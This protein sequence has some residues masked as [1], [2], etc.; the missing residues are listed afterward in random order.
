MTEEGALK[1]K[2]CEWLKER[3]A[4]VFV[5]DSVGIYDP[6]HRCFRKNHDPFR[7]KGVSDVLGVWKARFMAIECKIKGKYATTEQKHFLKEVS[8]AGGIAVLAY[9]L[10]DVKKALEP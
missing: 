9:S 8:E 2:I 7:R 6:V 5:H 10:D 4:L 1:R 3:G